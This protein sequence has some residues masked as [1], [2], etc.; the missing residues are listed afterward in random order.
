MR[1]KAFS[2]N[3]KYNVTLIRGMAQAD[4]QNGD[5]RVQIS[6]WENIPWAWGEEIEFIE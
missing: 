2:D 3:D 4:P 1:A 5:H 6:P